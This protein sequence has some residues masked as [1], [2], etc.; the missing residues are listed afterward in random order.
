MDFSQFSE[1]LRAV[2]TLPERTAADGLDERG[3]LRVLREISEETLR[4]TVGMKP[5]EV[6]KFRLSLEKND[7]D[8]MGEGG[9]ANATSMETSPSE[10][11]TDVG[12]LSDI[13]DD[14]DG[15][16]DDGDIDG[17]EV[18]KSG[19]DQPDGLVELTS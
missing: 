7:P 4:G 14:G 6:R 18:G 1:S 3:W 10:T 16:D 5:L 13:D 2:V 8:A 15:G 19:G 9:L 12:G 17:G 11:L